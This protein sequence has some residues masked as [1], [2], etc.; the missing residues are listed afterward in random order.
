MGNLR[1]K[2]TNEE[3]DELE[4]KSKN[5]FIKEGQ[6]AL[7]NQIEKEKQLKL[8]SKIE[9]LVKYTPNDQELGSKIRE[10]IKFGNIMGI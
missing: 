1:D 9:K 3:W 4:E 7:N 5:F 2:Y 10:L 6:I 8:V